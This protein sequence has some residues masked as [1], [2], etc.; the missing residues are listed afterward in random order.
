MKKLSS[1]VASVGGALATVAAVAGLLPGCTL[2][3]SFEV[4]MDRYYEYTAQATIRSTDGLERTVSWGDRFLEFPA[5]WSIGRLLEQGGSAEATDAAAP[6]WWK[7]YLAER[8]A[9]LAGDADPA[10]REAFRMQFGAGPW[11][12]VAEPA[13]VRVAGPTQG[14]ALHPLSPTAEPLP[15]CGTTPP[16]PPPPGCEI[17]A[18][19]APALAVSITNLDF[20][21]A[22]V[23]RDGSELPVQLTNTGSGRLCVAGAN[24]TGAHPDDFV[25]DPAPAT[26]SDCVI[27]IPEE[28][29]AGRAFLEGAGASCTLRLRFR[30]TAGGARR[31]QVAVSSNDPAAASVSLNLMGSGQAGHL[32]ISDPVSGSG[33]PVCVPPSTGGCYERRVTVRNAGPGVV[34]VDSWGG[35]GRWSVDSFVPFTPGSVVGSTLAVGATLSGLVRACSP[36]VAGSLSVAGNADNTPLRIDVLPQTTPAVCTP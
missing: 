35:D 21:A 24:P 14:E 3:R 2:D 34:R 10:V 18:G 33:M 5:G 29:R 27:N 9:A 28:R 31:A 25:L 1:F 19:T 20:G 8:L 16:P 7:R 23:G 17:V 15:L 30:P 6:D 13:V 22:D 11:C 26:P 36:A 32:E 4:P 12:L